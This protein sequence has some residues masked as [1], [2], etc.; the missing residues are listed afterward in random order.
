MTRKELRNASD[1]VVDKMVKIQGTNYDRSRKVTKSIKRRMDQMRKAGKSFNEIAKHF[2][3]APST[4]KYNIVEGFAEKKK[5][6]RKLYARNWKSNWWDTVDRVNY[7]R[8][9][10]DNKNFKI[11]F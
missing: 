2:N 10:I 3:V 4:V 1:A 5:A 6:D 8:S 9:L 7:K 11:C